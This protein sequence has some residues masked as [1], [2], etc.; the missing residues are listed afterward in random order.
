MNSLAVAKYKSE[1]NIF[2]LDSHDIGFFL[3][4]PSFLPPL[5]VSFPSAGALSAALELCSE[6]MWHHIGEWKRNDKSL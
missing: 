1:V 2:C 3:C 5:L 6:N 4:A